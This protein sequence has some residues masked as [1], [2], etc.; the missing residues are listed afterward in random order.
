MSKTRI[1]VL[2]VVAFVVIAVG[3]GVGVTV[4]LDRRDAAQV[5]AAQEAAEAAQAAAEREAAAQQEAL[6]QECGA[7]VDAYITTNLS[8]YV[9]H[10]PDYEVGDYRFGEWG[11]N[12]IARNTQ[13]WAIENLD[14]R[15]C[16]DS[17]YLEV[18]DAAKAEADAYS[19]VNAPDADELAPEYAALIGY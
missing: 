4:A 12:L 7:E 11:A 19:E 15:G 1:A 13:E 3:V 10:G 8:T 5:A 9:N 6:D 17:Y 18:F 16:D 2:A 14:P